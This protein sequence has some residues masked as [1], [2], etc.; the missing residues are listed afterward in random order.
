MSSLKYLEI[1]N[2]R[3]FEIFNLSF[4]GDFSLIS[5]KITNYNFTLFRHRPFEQLKN[6][7]ELRVNFGTL[8][9][10]PEELFHGLYNLKTLDLR[11]KLIK[12]IWDE[13]RIKTLPE[14]A[15]RHLYN[16]KTLDLSYNLIE[17]VHPLVFRHVTLLEQLNLEENHIES[18][19]EELFRDLYNLKT[20]DLSRNFINALHPLVIQHLTL[21]KQLNLERNPITSFPEDLLKGFSNLTILAISGKFSE[22]RSVFLKGLDNLIEFR[23]SYYPSLRI[24]EDFFSHSINLR[25]V[26]LYDN[27]VRYLPSNLFKNN[28]NLEIFQC[29]WNKLSTLPNGIFDGTFNLKE[30][31]LHGNRLEN[32]P[33]DSFHRL[34]KLEK[35]DLSFNRLTF[36]PKNIFL[37]TNNLRIL[38]LS[39]N[40]FSKISFD[41]NNNLERLRLYGAAMTCDG[42][43]LHFISTVQSNLQIS[44]QIFPDLK[45]MKCEGEERKLLDYT[46]FFAIRSHC[47]LNCECF[48]ENEDL[49]VDCNGKGINK[50]PDFLIENATA[51]DLSNNYINEFSTVNYRTWSKVTRLHLSNN[52]LFHFPDYV[53]L[54]NIEFLWLD[55]NRLTELPFGIMNLIDV[56]AEF[57]VYL[58]RNNWTC[59]CHSQFTKDWLLRNKRKIADFSDVLCAK[60]S[61]SLSFSET[62]SGDR[63]TQISEDNSMSVNR[64][65]AVNSVFGWKIAVA[66]LTSLILLGL[67]TFF[68]FVYCRKKRNVEK[69]AEPKEEEVIYYNVYN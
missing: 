8:K 1:E 5:L 40:N 43:L 49:T 25:K 60:S 51:V 11:K 13:N 57:T 16:V 54:P 19:P 44:L 47:P 4:H 17:S 37:P 20:L 22:L 27:D 58:S 62:V 69:V 21:L 28:K 63:C 67:I 56:S 42:E 61:S 24:E 52:S 29:S 59:D 41:F 34:S 39:A 26:A 33:E 46:Q 38:S 12:F 2:V 66:C 36:L 68:A 9:A 23:A 48:S 14:K 30:I 35:L 10:L 15:L 53:F 31:D 32:I 45:D 6:L 18:I 50:L 55:G 65:D 7:S 3:T 64:S